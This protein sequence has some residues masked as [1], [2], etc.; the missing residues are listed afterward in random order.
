VEGVVV[1][2]PTSLGISVYL[3]A[4]F[5]SKKHLGLKNFGCKGVTSN[6]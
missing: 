6:K 4:N 5:T 1:A 2:I 3:G